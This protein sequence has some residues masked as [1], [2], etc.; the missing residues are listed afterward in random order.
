VL[1]ALDRSPDESDRERPLQRVDETERDRGRRLCCV[2]CGHAITT[3]AARTSVSGHHLHTFCNPH[4]LVFEI[5]CFSEAPGCGATGPAEHFF[6][7]F[8]GYAWRM[9]VCRGC[10]AHL[11]WSYGDA[12]DFWGLIVDRLAEREDDES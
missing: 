9:G 2:V 8:P 6:S 10:H 7:W 5:G 1:H 11:G 3:T 4:G 12:P